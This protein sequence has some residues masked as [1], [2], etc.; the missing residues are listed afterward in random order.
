MRMDICDCNSCKYLHTCATLKYSEDLQTFFSI[1]FAKLS[2]IKIF[3]LNTQN[4]FLREWISVHVISG[5]Y[6]HTYAAL[7]HPEDLVTFIA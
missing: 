7:N 2:T 6:L 5:K 1:V 3:M 4:V